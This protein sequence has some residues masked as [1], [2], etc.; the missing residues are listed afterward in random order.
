MT[1]AE[2]YPS[3][4]SIQDYSYWR[5]GY[6]DTSIEIGCCLFPNE[7]ETALLWEQ[8]RLSMIEYLKQA[9]IG[10]RGIVKFQNGQPVAFASVRI[11]SRDPVFK[12]NELGEYYRIL[13]P[14]TYNLTLMY[15]CDYVIYSSQVFLTKEAP[16]VELNITLPDYFYQVYHQ[17]YHA[18]LDRYAL[19]CQKNQGPIKCPAND[20][21]KPPPSSS[22]ASSWDKRT[23]LLILSMILVSLVSASF[24]RLGAI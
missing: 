17:Q 13:L 6:A 20:K 2:W 1:P 23:S 11:D 19:F 22:S 18:K 16:L 14:G 4:G 5:Y 8:N 10:I 3:L 15:A 12:T 7:T 24:G 9:N 21:P